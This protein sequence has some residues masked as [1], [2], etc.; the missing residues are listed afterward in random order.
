MYVYNGRIIIIITDTS[1]NYLNEHYEQRLLVV[2]CLHPKKF[3]LGF[4]YWQAL[5][6][7]KITICS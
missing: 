2:T 5:H 7:L 3:C 4:F 6:A 1:K